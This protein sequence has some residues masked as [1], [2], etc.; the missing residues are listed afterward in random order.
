M[1]NGNP[2]HYTYLNVRF[3]IKAEDRIDAEAKAHEIE[4][5]CKRI[6]VKMGEKYTPYS[7]LWGELENG[8]TEQYPSIIIDFINGNETKRKLIRQ[9]LARKGFC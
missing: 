6:E 7:H 4:T 8:E 1:Y 9:E 5:H 3:C 2:W